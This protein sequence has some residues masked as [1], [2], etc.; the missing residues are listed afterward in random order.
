VG[1]RG[2]RAGPRLIVP[3]DLSLDDSQE[4]IADLFGRFFQRECPS[5]AV[6]A[7]EPLGF[8]STLWS[9]LRELG[10]PGVGVPESLGGGGASMAD[11]TLMAGAAGRVLAPV[12]VVDHVVAT[13]AHPVPELV[14]G[15]SIASLALRPAVDGTWRLVPAGAVADVVVGLD[16]DELVAVRSSPPG[17]GP[18][19]HA[20]LPLADRSTSGDRQVIGDRDAFVAARL[21]WTLLQAAQLAGLAQRALEIVTEY[22]KERTQFGR[23][24][25]GFQAVQHG[26][27]D[28]VAPIEGTNL[29]VSKAAWVFD[30]N[31]GGELDVPH[32]DVDDA[33]V[34][35]SMAFAFATEAAMA[36]TK[37]AVQY[38]GSYGVSRE[39]DIQLYYRRARG[40]P[41]VM[42]DPDLELDHLA[43][44][45]W[46]ATS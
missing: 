44:L 28:C 3:F 30:R 46:P 42:G 13:R 26:L 15:S 37:K 16:H 2:G 31:A 27:A 10:A 14:D 33:A 25:G 7:A 40:W 21:E 12:P 17:H 38:H 9:K 8:A 34:L 39:Y 4:A 35:A 23:P 43:D 29:L 24:V 19:N 5:A 45:L 6:R 1:D 20:D 18:R 32:G 41:L 11:L 22:V 36:V